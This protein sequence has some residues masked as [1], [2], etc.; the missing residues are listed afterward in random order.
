MLY[1]LWEKLMWHFLITT[2]FSSIAIFWIWE[3]HLIYTVDVYAWILGHKLLFIGKFNMNLISL[4][5]HNPTG[6]AG[7]LDQGLLF[8]VVLSGS[9]NS[10]S[11]SLLLPSPWEEP[12]FN[13]RKLFSL[14]LDQE[15]PHPIL[16]S[17]VHIFRENIFLC[18]TLKYQWK[19]GL[20]ER[21][22]FPP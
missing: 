1:R 9:P 12:Y 6:L 10:P 14:S 15:I 2:N 7:S 17:L 18:T 16:Q 11:L 21:K 19:L 3:K 8:A 5:S 13:L 4:F 20:W 22:S